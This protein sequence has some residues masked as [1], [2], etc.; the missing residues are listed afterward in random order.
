MKVNI[1]VKIKR[2]TNLKNLHV[3]CG[4]KQHIPNGK[5][6]FLEQKKDPP[7]KIVTPIYNKDSGYHFSRM[8][9]GPQIKNR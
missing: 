5:L 9:S 4:V 2:L 3:F 6:G 1:C 7:S 8:T